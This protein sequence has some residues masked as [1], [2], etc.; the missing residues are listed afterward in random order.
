MIANTLTVIKVKSGNIFG[1]YTE[2][3]WNMRNGFAIDF[4]A[5]YIQFGQ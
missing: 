4:K 5:F 3:K 2:K 1:G